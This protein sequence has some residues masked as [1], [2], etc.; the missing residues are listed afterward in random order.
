M[1]RQSGQGDLGS[2]WLSPELG[3]N[4]RL[5]RIGSVFDWRAV[6]ALVSGIYSSAKGRPSWPPLV[7]VKALL[8]Q[9]WYGLSD[10]GLEEALSDRLSFRRFVGLGLAEGQPDHSVISRFRKVLRER[11]LDRALFDEVGRQ[12]EARGL[13]LKS[14]TLMDATVVAAAVSKPGSPAGSRSKT[15][16]EAAWTRKG[17]KSSFGYKAHVGVDQ[18]SGLIRRAELTPAN[19]YES[20]MAEA[21]ICGDERAVYADKAYEHKERRARLKGLGIKDRILH[22][23]HKNQPGLPHWQARRNQL[24]SPIRAAVE[25]VFGTLKRGYG[26]TRVRYRGIEANLVQLRLLCIAF[27]LRRAIA[28]IN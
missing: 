7:L 8:V 19:I 3:R 24:I 14:G 18:G 2:A 1:H 16:P 12:L 11:G 26:Y 9:Q 22:R 10:P 13:L 6:E 15:D 23:S 21:L 28:L 20:Q 17:G 27:N 4:A 5:D 25:R